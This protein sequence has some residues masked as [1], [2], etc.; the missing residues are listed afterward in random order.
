MPQGSW[1]KSVF[2]DANDDWLKRGSFQK[3]QLNH[4]TTLKEN[5]QLPALAE[6]AL[7]SH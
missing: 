2:H 6:V 7:L 5:K 4:H 1:K 3:I